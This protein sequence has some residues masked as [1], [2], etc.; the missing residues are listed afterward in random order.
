VALEGGFSEPPGS[1]ACEKKRGGFVMEG[2][3]H[4]RRQKQSGN[5]EAGEAGEKLRKWRKAKKRGE[6]R[7]GGE[8]TRLA[9]SEF[10]T[11]SSLR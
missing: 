7:E 6:V 1:S 8:R 5:Q 10:A 4:Q 2:G 3:R 11:Q 9:K